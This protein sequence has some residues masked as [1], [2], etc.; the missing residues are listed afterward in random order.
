M[1]E[2]WCGRRGVWRCAVKL[3]VGVAEE[4]RRK[5]E[6]LAGLQGSPIAT[7]RLADKRGALTGQD[8]AAVV[9][10]EQIENASCR[11]CQNRGRLLAAFAGGLLSFIE[12]PVPATAIGAYFIESSAFGV[13]G[14]RSRWRLSIVTMGE[15]TARQL[16]QNGGLQGSQ[17]H[18]RAVRTGFAVLHQGLAV[19]TFR[20]RRWKVR[21]APTFRI[22]PQIHSAA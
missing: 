10:V 19:A 14:R 4:G 21:P 3:A 9:F 5:R 22:R 2:D 18:E 20:G 13:R 7:A 8:R 17:D 16:R 6:E 1:L 15:R 11:F 12:R